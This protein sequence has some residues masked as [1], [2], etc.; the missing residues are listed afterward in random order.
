M[1]EVQLEVKIFQFGLLFV[2]ENTIYNKHQSFCFT[3]SGDFTWRVS[4][5]EELVGGFT[6]D[7]GVGIWRYLIIILSS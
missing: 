7:D 2:H 4:D 6:G 3:R 1:F 5:C